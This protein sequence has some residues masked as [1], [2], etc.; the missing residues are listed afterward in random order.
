[1]NLEILFPSIKIK[2]RDLNPLIDRRYTAKTIQYVIEQKNLIEL[3]NY[4][5]ITDFPRR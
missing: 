4:L 1:M 2:E 5:I 3:N